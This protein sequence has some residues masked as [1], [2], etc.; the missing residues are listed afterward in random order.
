MNRF[1]LSLSRMTKNGLLLLGVFLLL[2]SSC[3]KK[4]D[5]DVM[6][7]Y[8]PINLNV[9]VENS[10]GESLLEPLTP[11]NILDSDMYIIFKGERFNVL[12]GRPEE[13]F[14]PYP[15]TRAYMP[16]WYGAFIAPYFYTYPDSPVRS[17]RIFIGEFAGDGPDENL[18]LYILDKQYEIS[19]TNTYNRKKDKFIRHSYLEGVETEELFTYKII[20]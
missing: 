14:F 11:G 18:S 2:L 7:D 20:L 15:G 13:P 9:L 16:D 1:S 19:F 3:D 10:D 6:I 17:N 4:S 12:M 5:E 8:S